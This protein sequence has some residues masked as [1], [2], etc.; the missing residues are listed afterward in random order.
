MYLPPLRD[1]Y[2]RV[3][4]DFGIHYFN[5]FKVTQLKVH[6]AAVI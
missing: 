4:A 6:Q 1:S 5:N 2:S 3:L